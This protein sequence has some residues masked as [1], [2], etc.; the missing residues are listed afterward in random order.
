M[1]YRKERKTWAGKWAMT[2][3]REH[4]LSAHPF[5]N[6]VTHMGTMSSRVDEC[7]NITCS[8]CDREGMWPDNLPRYSID[9]PLNHPRTMIPNTFSEFYH[10][11]DVHSRHWWKR[12]P[13]TPSD[14]VR[15]W[16]RLMKRIA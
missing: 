6:L 5:K 9:F 2:M 4:W 12:I 16:K 14:F 15:K 8:T 11:E 3:Y 1:L 10:L 7:G 13:T